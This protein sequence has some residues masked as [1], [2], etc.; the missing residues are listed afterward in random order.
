VGIAGFSRMKALATKYNDAPE[1]ASRPF[2][3]DRGGF[4]MGEGAGVLVLES[5][6]HALRRGAAGRILCELYGYGMSGDAHHVSS[7]HPEG[8][9]AQMAMRKAI[10]DPLTRMATAASQRMP[11]TYAQRI[12]PAMDIWHLNAHATSTPMGD[13]IEVAAAVAALKPKRQVLVS[14]AKGNIGHLLG[15]AGAVETIF[16]IK[17]LR[18]GVVPATANLENP[19]ETGSEH[20][21]LVRGAPA[22]VAADCDEPLFVLANSFGFGGTN[23]S[24]LLGQYY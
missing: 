22:R 4:V 8:L 9:G 18:S 7:P 24:L 17:S 10:D 3:R 14:S 19:I 21:E 1:K 16:A 12:D 11:G 5:E 20:V 15:A 13:E 6:E 23:A 2:D